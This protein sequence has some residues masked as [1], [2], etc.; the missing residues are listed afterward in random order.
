MDIRE[1]K[2]TRA[3]VSTII[4]TKRP[5]S[6]YYP[7]LGNKPY[8]TRLQASP[9]TLYYNNHQRQII[10]YDKVKEANTKDVQIPDM[11][12][13][14]NLF[15]YELRYKERVSKQLKNN[16][17][18]G[19]LSNEIFYQTIIQNWYTE[20]QTIQKLKNQSFMID[21]INS[22]KEA[23]E[24]LFTHLLQQAGQSFIDEF[25]NDLK[26]KKAFND[27]SEYTKL[28]ADLNKMLAA[29]RGEQTDLMQE[30]E[31]AIYNVAKYAR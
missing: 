5:P 21:N 26:A 19:L 7:F 31:T 18:G 10:F 27:R 2:V 8:F 16:V 9:D 23:K 15:R 28:K 29:Q 3:D 30:L 22:K 20:F 17:T 12:N 6:D 4:P 13:Q 24:A 1:A 14:S 25:L 11:L